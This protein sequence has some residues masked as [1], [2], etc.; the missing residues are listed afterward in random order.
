MPVMALQA[1]KAAVMISSCVTARP[2]VVRMP[3]C[4][5][6]HSTCVRASSLVIQSPLLLSIISASLTFGRIAIM[7][8]CHAH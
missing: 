7:P 1:A 4:A 2:L 6:S 8:L 3:V 5:Q